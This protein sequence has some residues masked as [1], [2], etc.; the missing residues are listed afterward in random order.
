[1]A[2]SDPD[3]YLIVSRETVTAL[4]KG[5]DNVALWAQEMLANRDEEAVFLRGARVYFERSG[6]AKRRQAIAFL[7]HTFRAKREDLKRYLR[8]K[9]LVNLKD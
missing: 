3:Y 7:A 1:V 5:T 8:F 4:S 6:Q 9:G 2:D